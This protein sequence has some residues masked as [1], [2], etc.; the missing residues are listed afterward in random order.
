MDLDKTPRTLGSSLEAHVA[1]H[2]LGRRILEHWIAARPELCDKLQP[3]ID[4]MFLWQHPDTKQPMLL[5][6]DVGSWMYYPLHEEKPKF[7]TG[8]TYQLTTPTLHG[9]EYTRAVHC[10]SM[11]TLVSSVVNGLAAGVEPG[12]GNITGVYAYRKDSKVKRA[13]SSSGY[14][15]Y[16]PLCPCHQIYFGLRLILEVQ[17]WR[18]EVDLPKISVG[19]GQLC[20]QPGSFHLTGFYVHI[21][22]PEDLDVLEED[23]ATR[24]LWFYC[25]Q[26]WIPRYEYCPHEFA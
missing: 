21:M 19:E 1:A 11:Y 24:Q 26:Q 7:P 10:C 13:V 8:T 16:E 5:L 17:E 18:V 9:H 20:L 15:T 23:S 4:T 6:H 14:C 22:T 2:K 3:P 12:K 25:G